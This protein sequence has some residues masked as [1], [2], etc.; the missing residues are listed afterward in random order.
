MSGSEI[1]WAICKSAPCSRQ[2]TTPAPHRSVFYRPDALP[3]TQPIASKHWR[4]G[5]GRNT[6]TET[7]FQSVS[8]FTFLVPA[9]LGSPG[10]RAVKRVCVCVCRILNCTTQPLCR[11]EVKLQWVI[12]TTETEV[13]VKN[14][15]GYV[16]KTVSFATI[17]YHNR[18]KISDAHQQD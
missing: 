10:K 14:L 2:I 16:E 15:P 3:A 5:N 4:H 12:L 18:L 17:T 1:R 6:V 7:E 13:F 11:R 9:R 8:S